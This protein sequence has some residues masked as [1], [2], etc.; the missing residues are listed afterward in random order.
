MHT[1]GRGVTVAL[2]GSGGR[3]TLDY[4]GFSTA[5]G[6]NLGV[7]VLTLNGTTYPAGSAT[8]VRGR[9]TGGVA[10]IE[11]VYGGSA[12]DVLLGRD[13][14]S[15]VLVGGAGADELRGGTGRD[16]LIGGLGADTLRGAG[17]D[18]ILIGGRAYD[19]PTSANL[20]ALG[21]VMDEWGSGRT[22]SQRVYNLSNGSAAKGLDNSTY[23][24][25]AN[26]TTYLLVGPSAVSDDGAADQLYG[27]TGVDWFFTKTSGGNKD[28]V[29]S[30]TGE[31]QTGL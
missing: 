29:N 12:A 31:V 16:L 2:N 30:E 13:G 21:L 1:G 10:G 28:T 17:G 6:V 11:N 5:V 22:Y 8:A 19:F 18:D 24:S 26:G 25:R 9:S 4:S 27:D 7:A 20:T 23:A 15:N 3:D 14:Q